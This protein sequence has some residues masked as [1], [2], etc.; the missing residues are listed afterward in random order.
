MDESE[1][2]HYAFSSLTQ[3][4]AVQ[5]EIVLDPEDQHGLR[6][7]QMSLVS[8]GNCNPVVKDDS[9]CVDMVLEEEIVTD[10]HHDNG[11]ELMMILAMSDERDEEQVQMSTS[12][13]TPDASHQGNNNNN[14]LNNCT[15]EASAAAAATVEKSTLAQTQS[16]LLSS[17]APPTA[18]I[19]PL[20]KI[21][22]NYSANPN[23]IIMKIQAKEPPDTQTVT[24]DSSQRVT[25]N[26]S[27]AEDGQEVEDEEDE[28]EEI[29]ELKAATSATIED[30]KSVKVPREMKQLQK[31]VDSSKVLTDFLNNTTNTSSSTP[32]NKVRKSRKAQGRPK[33]GQDTAAPV[34]AGA[35]NESPKRQ[36]ARALAAME[37]QKQRVFAE[38]SGSG[39]DST[40]GTT[41]DDST[42]M[43]YEGGDDLSMDYHSDNETNE[44]VASGGT[45][46]MSM[47]LLPKVNSNQALEI[48]PAPKV[49][50]RT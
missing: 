28:E 25:G 10:T 36:S 40:T 32:G 46:S 30:G 23:R 9:Q 41:A 14:N 5:E 34:A 15:N 35:D 31:M 11:D 44:S 8:T 29:I 3:M 37:A 24:A 19:L 48:V 16:P 1:I 47:K 39:L 21:V 13:S 27:H 38:V 26:G 43:T 20:V 17:S 45:D 18:T 6:P 7:T 4:D 33:K 12:I 49:S 22:P 42:E 2:V 50:D